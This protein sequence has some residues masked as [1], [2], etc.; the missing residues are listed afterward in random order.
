MK[1]IFFSLLAIAAIASCA[2]TETVYDDLQSEIK[3]KPAASVVTKAAIDGTVYPT[4]ESFDVY[5]YWADVESGQ[6]FT[7]G[8]LYL[9]QEG[10]VEFV[11]KGAFWGGATA[12][13]WPK[14]GS[15]RFAAYSPA[16]VDMT[17]TLATDTYS[18]ANYVQS[19]NTAETVDLL[20]A[21]TTVSYNSL[22]S[23]QNVSVVFEHALSWITIQVKA[24][25]AASAA[26]FT[27]NKVTVNDVVTKGDL[28]A[29]MT[30]QKAMNWTL[31]STKAD[32]VV[33]NDAQALTT[34]AAPVETV[35]A[36]T[37]VIPQP[38]T[39]VTVEYTQNSINGAAAL[40]QELTV[41]LVLGQENASWEAGKHYV[42][43]LVFGLDE[44]LLN[45]SVSEWEDGN[46]GEISTGP[47]M[48]ETTEEFV[49][50]VAQGGQVSLQADVNL[51]EFATKAVK[52]AGVVL[53]KDIVIEGNGFTVSTT[54]VRA[55]QIID[56]KN[57]T[58]KNLN[59]AATGERGFQLQSEGQT[60][61]LEN[62]VATS[63]N[64][65]VNITSTSANANV[66]IK[67]CE[68]HGLTPINVWG[69]NHTI[70]VE[71]TS[72]YVEDNNDE[73]YAAVYNVAENTTVYFN[74]GK[75]VITGSD[76]EGTD[77][78]LTSGNSKVVFNGTEGNLTF[79]GAV[80]AI[81]YGENRYTFETLAEAV[82]YAKNGE[83]IEMLESVELPTYINV[84][85]KNITINLNGCNIVAKYNG[86]AT[87]F[88][89]AAN[90]KLTIN[91]EG[92]VKATGRPMWVYG[93]NAEAVING[94][95]FI[96]SSE[97]SECEVM[98]INGADSKLIINGGKF[99]AAHPSVGT[100]DEYAVLNILDGVNKTSSIV[101]NGGS[102]YKFNP[103][104]N[105]SEGANTNFV[106]AGY[107]V[108]ENDGWY[109]V[110]AA[111]V[112]ELS[113]DV[114]LSETMVISEHTIINLNGKTIT[115]KL[116]NTSTDV[117]V[118]EAGATLVINGEGTVEAVS[119]ND[120]YA[121]IADGTVII[122]GGTFKSGVDANGKP[123]AVV[124]ARGNGEVYVNGGNFPNENNSV[125]VLNKKDAD[126]ATTVI[127][128]TGGTFVNFNP[129][130][131]AAENPGTNFLAAGYKV[132]A[133]GN[134][135]TVVKK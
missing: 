15:L 62:V 74:G 124:Y 17:H 21:P 44:I 28:E 61:V 111:K 121:V 65:T 48:V 56:A 96:G 87:A 20:V 94:G 52:E 1:K 90:A 85:E 36:G 46:E 108:V 49:E 54:A 109:T 13:Y 14:S 97:T 72:V 115:N 101:V 26:A 82:E 118:V 126:R 127:E 134:V 114:V 30:G 91:G 57:V 51:D 41:D 32:Y 16:S 93:A 39:S 47:I 103:A 50:A 3:I 84:A 24:K 11:N 2:K 76:C 75:V 79:E 129:E 86:D 95:H 110:E 18:V 12:C 107:V 106:A 123:N 104:N 77:A 112:V 113:A 73:E 27:V 100:N 133:N 71:N 132:V 64:R 89:V 131:N 99:E 60:L 58:I 25:D 81:N 117:L 40:T 63:A 43:T 70:V 38:T 31:S 116:G 23:A 92:Q 88:G 7:Q 45:P 53:N 8:T 37:V 130:N 80:C 33:Y 22:T 83:T 35:P 122:N 4:T 119:G 66:S 135:Y 105:A 42:Y 120:G 68:L 6:S 9:G 78:A 34:E 29:V 10:A 5:A 98:Y 125:Y 19:N 67:N 102:F 128:V 59:L 69:E 55:F